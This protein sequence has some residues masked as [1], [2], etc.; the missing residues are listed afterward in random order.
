MSDI[1]PPKNQISDIT[2]SGFKKL[3]IRYQ[4]PRSTPAPY[5]RSTLSKS[6]VDFENKISIYLA[7]QKHII[8]FM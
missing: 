8:N 3:D 1:R 2:R 5:N 6:C 4:T 7:W